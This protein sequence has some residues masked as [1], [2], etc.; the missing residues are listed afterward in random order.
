MAGRPAWQRPGKE[1]VLQMNLYQVITAIEKTAAYQPTVGTIVRNDIFRLNASPVVQYG[2]FA[3]LQGEHTSSGDGTLFQ[4][5]FTLFYVDRLTADKGNEVQIQSAGIETLEN[6][7]RVLE[8]LGI[9]AGDY[10]YQTFNQRFSDECA[11]VFCRVTLETAKDSICA[12]AF[13]YLAGEDFALTWDDD[14]HV[15]KW[16]TDTRTI[17]II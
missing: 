10:T 5:N 9:F 14:L 13:D 17:Y 15:W 4:W 1:G 8:G 16:V 3:W 11:G 2:A 7:L 6:I 12:E